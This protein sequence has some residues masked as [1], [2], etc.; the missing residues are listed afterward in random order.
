[1][2]LLALAVGLAFVPPLASAATCTYKTPYG[3][4]S[5]PCAEPAGPE[6]QPWYDEPLLQ[7]GLAVV[8]LVASAGAAGYTYWRVRDRRKTLADY[9]AAV[10]RTYLE[11]KRAPD[12]G[13]PKLVDLRAEM[14]AR[15]EQGRL[16]DAQFLELDKRVSEHIARL[17]LF[18]IDR[19]FGDLPP[20]FLAELRHLVADGV[21][22]EA[23]ADLVEAHAVQHRIPEARRTTL[24]RV[25]RSWAREDEGRQSPS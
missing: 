24:V 6:D 2:A 11:A 12:T 5:G 13:I 4:F 9:L 19:G 3:E 1:M 15:H 10:E 16:E 14:R 22:S 25:V 23:E 7:L 20:P 17:R 8:G 18:E 21:V